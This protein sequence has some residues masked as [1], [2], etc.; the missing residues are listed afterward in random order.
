MFGN[1]CSFQSHKSTIFLSFQK[2]AGSEVL[3]LATLGKFSTKR[4][5]RWT[6]SCLLS[7]RI[8]YLWVCG[9]PT[10]HLHTEEVE[11][12]S[13]R[14]L[15]SF[16][17]W[18]AVFVQQSKSQERETKCQLLHITTTASTCQLCQ[19]CVSLF[20]YVNVSSFFF[21]LSCFILVTTFKSLF[22][23]RSWLKEEQDMNLCHWNILLSTLFTDGVNFGFCLPIVGSNFE[24]ERKK[25]DGLHAIYVSDLNFLNKKC[26]DSITL[27]ENVQSWY[28]AKNSLRLKNQNI[29]INSSKQINFSFDKQNKVRQSPVHCYT[30][31]WWNFS[32]TTTDIC[33]PTVVSR[34]WNLSGSARRCQR[35]ICK[36][37]GEALWSQQVSNV[38]FSQSFLFAEIQQG[39]SSCSTSTLVC[40]NPASP[41][42]TETQGEKRVASFP[43]LSLAS[44]HR[45][46][47]LLNLCA[48]SRRRRRKMQLNI[49]VRKKGR[50]QWQRQLHGYSARLIT[51]T[52]QRNGLWDSIAG[53][54]QNSLGNPEQF[55]RYVLLISTIQFRLIA[56]LSAFEGLLEF[57][58]FKGKGRGWCGGGKGGIR[59]CSGEP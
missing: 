22:A 46:K 9:G 34:M 35:Q 39:V 51:E 54:R 47:T 29:H 15:Y 2:D 7:R 26:E 57:F 56:S 45:T 49:S 5:F 43:R 21:F 19:T 1:I 4:V 38:L 8:K 23:S 59:N 20:S 10:F 28:Q 16:N 44:S 52:V 53:N 13:C 37:S 55:Q 50:W 14:H 27:S 36:R 58:F 18:E 31:M 42:T 24:V 33:R 11:L 41:G 6:Y 25:K 12:S 30:W 40:H 3:L 17:R 32:S 48:Y